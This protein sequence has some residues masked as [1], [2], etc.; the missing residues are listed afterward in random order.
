MPD[1]FGLLMEVFA[2]CVPGVVVAIASGENN[3][4]DLHDSLT[5]LRFGLGSG[6]GRSG[7]GWGCF[8]TCGAPF[9]NRRLTIAFFQSG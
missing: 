8:F 2:D 5:F 3:N 4:T 6:S 1:E 9:L 7:R